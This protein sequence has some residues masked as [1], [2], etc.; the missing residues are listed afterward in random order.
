MK[1]FYYNQRKLR[2]WAIASLFIFLI[3]LGFTA[4]TRPEIILVSVIKLIALLSTLLAFYVYL[5]P[6][7]LARIDSKGIK[8]D[9]GAML[10]WSDIQAIEKRK[11]GF[12]GRKIL[13]LKIKAEKKYPLTFMQKI[14]SFS[15]YGAFSIPLYAMTK[16]DAL[17]VEEEIGAHFLEDSHKTN[18]REAQKRINSKNKNQTNKKL[19]K[20]A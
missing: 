12:W 1:V 11:I 3:S 17:A 2:N 16:E 7:E 10:R 4:T 5:R 13:K 8:I 18:S 9:H 6:Q 20:N 15:K 14:S 19:K